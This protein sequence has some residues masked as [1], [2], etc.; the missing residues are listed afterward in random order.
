MCLFICDLRSAGMNL[1]VCSLR[2]QPDTHPLQ[3]KDTVTDTDVKP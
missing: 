2:E 1:A 3:L